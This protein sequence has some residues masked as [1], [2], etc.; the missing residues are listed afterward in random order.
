VFLTKDNRITQKGVRAIFTKG[1]LVRRR[2]L[3]YP[4]LV[5]AHDS[6]VY[7]D[8]AA[9]IGT[10]PQLEEVPEDAEST[11]STGFRNYYWNWTNRLFQATISLNRSILD[12]DQTGQT[13]KI[14]TNLA[15]RLANL[16]DA[17]LIARLL[18]DTVYSGEW[19]SGS[20]VKLFSASHLAPM[21]SS[22]AQ[23]N[24]ITGST[25]TSFVYNT[26]LA[27]VA[28]QI[29]TDF[30]KVK[31]A[32]RAIKDDQGQ[33]WHNDTLRSESMVILCGPLMEEPMRLAFM[34]DQIG[35]TN[36]TL[37][38]AVREVI[39][40]NYWP[41]LSTSAD[42]ADWF[43]FVTNEMNRPLVYSRFRH[44]RDEEI[45]DNPVM[46]S[47][48]ETVGLNMDDLRNL[49]TVRIQTNMKHQGMDAEADVI[50]NR[51]FVMGAEWRGEIL[52]G[53]WRNG[54][55]VDNAAS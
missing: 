32:M 48:L 19:S 34:A 15:G 53:E 23:S 51:R 6:Y 18:G 10:V 40:S 12:F 21:N 43:L 49:S 29:Q 11:P 35:A 16:P 45:L 17:I 2:E 30:R 1:Y 24:L 28:Q 54:Y 37:K 36:N 46:P 5:E 38:G 22:T 47:D 41:A 31:A 9:A 55:K 50:L 39:V 20:Q 7:R 52:G 42:A 3:I 27:T 4:K 44:I 8:F 26:S 14:L 13:R 25:P 33:P